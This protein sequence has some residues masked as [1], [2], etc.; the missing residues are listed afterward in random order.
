[1]NIT[2]P[3]HPPSHSIPPST[4]NSQSP[5]TSPTRQ[6]SG[7]HAGW[8]IAEYHARCVLPHTR[9]SRTRK[10]YPPPHNDM[11]LAMMTTYCGEASLTAPFHQQ[12]RIVVARQEW[13]HPMTRA[14]ARVLPPPKSSFSQEARYWQQP[15]LQSI[16]SKFRTLLS[17]CI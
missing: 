10:S 13:V 15:K 1:M 8:Q 5:Q 11:S 6:H 7:G 2:P 17:S 3:P 9:W 16:L 12:W 4:W 14:N